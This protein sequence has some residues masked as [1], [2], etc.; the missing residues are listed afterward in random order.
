MRLVSCSCSPSIFFTLFA[1]LV[2]KQCDKC[3]LLFPCVEGGTLI[4]I[5]EQRSRLQGSTTVKVFVEF[6]AKCHRQ[7]RNVYL[8]IAVYPQISACWS[9]VAEV[10]CR[11]MCPD[12]YLPKAAFT[13]A[14]SFALC[15]SARENCYRHLYIGHKLLEDV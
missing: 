14:G 9:P 13:T 15:Y 1:K 10:N 4:T 5:F 8:K 2:S 11:R 3:A 12:F 7:I 6:I